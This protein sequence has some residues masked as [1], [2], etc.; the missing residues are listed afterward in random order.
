MGIP[1]PPV[2]EWA[3]ESALTLFCTHKQRIELTACHI[4]AGGES[5]PRERRNMASDNNINLRAAAT[6]A[7]AVHRHAFL[8]MAHGNWHVLRTLVRLLDAPWADIYLHID[9]NAKGIDT[10]DIRRQAKSANLYFVPRH[11]VRWGDESQIKGP[12]HKISGSLGRFR[13]SDFREL[14]KE[15]CGHRD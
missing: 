2:A 13:A 9:R 10:D 5:P 1:E 7:A 14:R 3:I 6:T 4:G 8:I 12:Y 15:R 11:K